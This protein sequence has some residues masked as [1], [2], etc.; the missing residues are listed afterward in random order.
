MRI[1]VLYHAGFTYTQTVFH[2]LDSFRRYSRHQVE[3]FN[4]DQEYGTKLD[5]FDYDAV[6]VGYC[7]VSVGRVNPPKLFRKLIPALQEFPGTKIVAV[8]DE[9]DF[10]NNVKRFLVAIGADVVLTCVPKDAVDQVYSDRQFGQTRFETV[11]TGYVADDLIEDSAAVRPLA[12]RDISLGYRGRDLPYRLGDLGWHKSEIGRRFERRCRERGIACDIASDEDSRFQGDAWLWFVR[13]CR[14]ML[15]SPS[16]AN[17]FDFDG[18]LHESIKQR[19]LNNNGLVYADVRERVEKHA[20]AFDMGQVSA[21]IFEAAASRTAMALLRGNYSGVL[22]ADEHYVPIETDY[23]NID[24]VLDRILDLD[25]MQA[26]A[27]RAY[28]HVIG[29]P[30]NHYMGFVD[31]VDRLFDEEARSI[32][33]FV[34]GASKLRVTKGPLGNDPYMVEKLM[35]LR[36]DLQDQVHRFGEVMRLAADRRLDVVK[37]HDGSYRVLKFDRPHG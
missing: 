32:D 35:A 11:L 21:R 28:D 26:M 37:H 13:R 27:D 6:F 1:L 3:F 23:S 25:E 2:Y 16:G 17:V 31:R 36:K 4:V 12:E 15:G 14:V 9:Y 33:C 8:Q 24:D 34:A 5:F 10:T 29:N 22:R 30:A 20:V 18:Q 19:Y 7:V